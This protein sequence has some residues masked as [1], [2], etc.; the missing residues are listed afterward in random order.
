MQEGNN[1]GLRLA[2]A[3]HEGTK[4]LLTHEVIKGIEEQDLWSE[5]P[6]IELTHAIFSARR[7]FFERSVLLRL[8][9]LFLMTT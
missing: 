7:Y 4:E 1:I 5:A 9:C 2:L 3:L 8:T 6:P